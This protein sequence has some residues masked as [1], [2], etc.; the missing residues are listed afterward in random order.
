MVRNERQKR[1]R[2]SVADAVAAG[3][4]AASSIKRY[5]SGKPL[6]P[7]PARKDRER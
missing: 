4:R 1:G 7:I 5:L 3:Q 2:Q 6:D